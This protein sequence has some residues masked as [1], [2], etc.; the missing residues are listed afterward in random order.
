MIFPVQ[1]LV[2]CRY[3]FNGADN[4]MRHL[5]YLSI[6]I[7][8]GPEGDPGLSNQTLFLEKNMEIK[9]RSFTS[10]TCTGA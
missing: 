9:R 6:Q 8:K 3:I 7:E 4:R 5:K 2:L 10:P 1:E